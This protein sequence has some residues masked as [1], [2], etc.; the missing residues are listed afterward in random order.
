[1]AKKNRTS[2]DGAAASVKKKHVGK[3]KEGVIQMEGVVMEALPDNKFRVKLENDHMVLGHTAGKM[4]QH[5]IRILEG[6]RVTVELTPY[7]LDRG[8]IVF[9]AK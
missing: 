7:D 9:R 4:R 5:S 8:R 1:M 3:E 2:R 6:D